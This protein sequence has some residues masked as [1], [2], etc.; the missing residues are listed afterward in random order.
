MSCDNF[1]GFYAYA[2]III[3]KLS[4]N[5]K[6]MHKHLRDLLGSNKLFWGIVI[7][8]V[9]QALFIAITSKF[10]MP[11]DE[12]YHFALTNYYSHN[13]SPVITSQP[14]ELSLMGDATRL[15][16]YLSHYALSFPL[17]IV[18]A[19]GGDLH[20]QVVALRVINIL[21]VVAG[22]Y[23]FRKFLIN[24]TKIGWVAN[25]A[26]L[27]FCLLPVTSYLAAHINYDNLLLVALAGLLLS[28][29]AIITK[30]NSGKKATWSQLMIL[31]SV[32]MLG[33]LVKFTF[34]PM[35]AAVGLFV[36]GF[37]SVRRAWPRLMRRSV[38]KKPSS[39]MPRI[40]IAG[41]I[42]LFIVSSGMFMERYGGNLIAYKTLQPDCSSVQSLQTCMRYGPW[43]RNYDLKMA[44][45]TDTAFEGRSIPGY[46]INIWAP[47]MTK[48]LG[49]TGPNNILSKA[50]VMVLLVLV[51]LTGIGLS[52]A[53]L[54]RRK[55]HLTLMLL[56]AAALYFLA[57]LQ[58][59]YSE[60]MQF[61]EVVAV[62]G[63][64]ALPFLIP[65]FA[66][67]IKGLMEF[68]LLRSALWPSLATVAVATLV[69]YSH[70]T[71]PTEEYAPVV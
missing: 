22:L 21:F 16:S 10:P 26:V 56:S 48:G 70:L 50:V 39:S 58:R 63:R 12:S 42:V 47:L 25:A 11:F 38:T 67:G 53:A 4:R 44:A 9:C 45:K 71:V 2:K 46:I 24:L 64:Y 68:K 3:D 61:H 55:D 17:R 37:I 66:L 33:C 23:L 1:L 65:L 6:N 62:Q 69:S 32:A 29:Q 43:A 52:I 8:F 59:N 18:Q 30:V 27:L 49:Y 13:I 60:F 5:I 31:V 34:L 14:E 7:L 15:G 20:M 54:L 57:L 51:L 35:A 36:I 40:K 28:A 41:A 19:F